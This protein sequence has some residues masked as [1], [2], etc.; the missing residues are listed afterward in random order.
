[1]ARRIRQFGKLGL[2]LVLAWFVALRV[3]A[4]PLIMAAPEPGLMALCV[5][6]QVIYVSTDTGQPVETDTGIAAD[7]C[8]FFGVTA[9]LDLAEPT[10][11][12][13]EG[14]FTDLTPLHAASQTLS[15]A[16]VLSHGARAPP[17]PV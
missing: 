11:Q 12:P 7:P 1:M 3:V 17:V 10:V 9:G 14:L 13:V 5:G 4:Q 2:M 16:P 6:G 8:P 15:H